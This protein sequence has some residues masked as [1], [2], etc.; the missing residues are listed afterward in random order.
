MISFKFD[1][2][3]EG[4]YALAVWDASWNSYNNCYIV[5]GTRDLVLVDTGKLEHLDTL[6]QALFGFGRNPEDVTTILLTHGHHD[7]VGGSVA[8]PRAAKFIHAADWPLLSREVQSGFAASLPDDGRTLEFECLLLG[9]HTTGSVAFFHPTTKTLFSG[10]HICFFGAP[11][12]PEGLVGR[13]AEQR[14]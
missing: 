6:V 12:L 4:V 2:V 7:H 5:I 8:F 10:D 14:E 13:G 11:L 3:V 9:Q 1:Q